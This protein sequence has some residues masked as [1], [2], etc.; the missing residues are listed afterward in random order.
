MPRYAAD[1]PMSNVAPLRFQWQTASRLSI[2]PFA[3]RTNGVIE[4]DFE[5]QGSRAPN[6]A[7]KLAERLS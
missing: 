2:T 1:L 4:A 3:V 6:L 5:I 7:A